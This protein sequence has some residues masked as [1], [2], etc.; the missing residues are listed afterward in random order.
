LLIGDNIEMHG[1]TIFGFNISVVDVY[2]H[3]HDAKLVLFNL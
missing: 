3:V 1:M 2:V